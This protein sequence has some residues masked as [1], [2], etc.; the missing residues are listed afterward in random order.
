MPEC[1]LT[2]GASPRVVWLSNFTEP[3]KRMEGGEDNTDEKQ[4]V[5]VIRRS[6]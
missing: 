1:D 5:E 6:V 2:Q 3:H 4:V